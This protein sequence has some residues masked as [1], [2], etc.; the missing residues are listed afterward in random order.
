MRDDHR[1]KQELIAEVVALRKQV[2]DLKEASVVRWRI[3]QA[4]RRSEEKYREL[5]E[6]APGGLCR[7]DADGALEQANQLVSE[8]L[9]CE[10]QTEALDFA[11]TF[12]LFEDG[13]E[14]E[15]LIEAL[16][17]QGDV[18]RF[19]ARFRRRGGSVPVFLSGRALREPDDS[20]T[21]YVLLVEA[22]TTCE[23]LRAES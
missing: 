3:E 16:R 15:A 23:K 9:G 12:G 18:H 4:L 14:R 11:A 17:A 5:V 7:L 21:G 8:L 22:D 6:L 10:T 2:A 1:P 19:A 20:V 13:G